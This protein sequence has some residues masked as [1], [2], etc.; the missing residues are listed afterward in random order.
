[1]LVLTRK[2]TQQ[3]VI[4]DTIEI[5]VLE[6]KNRR[7]KLGIRCPDE[8]PIQR[9]EIMVEAAYRVPRLRPQPR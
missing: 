4:D 8:I 1:M 7:V 2:A 3:I 9:K 5:T 6:I